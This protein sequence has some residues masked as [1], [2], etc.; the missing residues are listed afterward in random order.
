MKKLILGIAMML[1]GFIG[2]AI[3]CAGAMSSQF[4]IN[5]S[6]N[7]MDIWRIFGITPIAIT[8]TV[9]A[10]LGFVCSLFGILSKTKE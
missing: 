10:I 2:I 3:L 5:G 1:I 7:F 6:N 9:I 4:T 8:F